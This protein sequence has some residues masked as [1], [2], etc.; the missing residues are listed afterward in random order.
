[1]PYQL[2]A[3]IPPTINV[4]SPA[5]HQCTGQSMSQQQG[6]RP[7]KRVC[8]RSQCG[9]CLLIHFSQSPNITY[10]HPSSPYQNQ[11]MGSRGGQGGLR[12]VRC[13]GTGN[14]QE[15]H[16]NKIK[17]FHNL[18]YCFIS[19]YDVDHPGN[20]FPVA[21]QN[22]ICPTSRVMRHTCMPT[23]EQSW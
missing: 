1:M 23:R 15:T 4:P 2:A 20:A 6:Q 10:Q 11:P 18:H 22:I 8:N 17:I 21:I 14:M 16:T 19:G 13:E 3:G 12:Q 5:Q 7:R 9:G